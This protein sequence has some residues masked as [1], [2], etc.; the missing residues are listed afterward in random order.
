MEIIYQEM[1]KDTVLSANIP[2]WVKLDIADCIIVFGRLEQKII[3]IAW[4]MAGTTETKERLKRA[5]QPASDNFDD[6]ISVIEEAGGTKFD[7]L[8]NGFNKLAQDRNLI[9]HGHWIMAGDE[10]Y[11]VWHKFLTDTDSV[12]GNSS[13]NTALNTSRPRAHTSSRHVRSGTTWSR[14]NNRRDWAY[15]IAL[16]KVL[17]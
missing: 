13:R 6:L 16:R 12:M 11:V 10:P 9:A 8:R 2:D 17:S 3:E 4:D 1:P 7:A 15:L 5:R 14:T